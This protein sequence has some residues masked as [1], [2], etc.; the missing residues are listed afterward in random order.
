MNFVRSIVFGIKIIV[1][2]SELNVSYLLVFIFSFNE[3]IK[4]LN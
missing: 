4:Y 1:K 2:S 3:E